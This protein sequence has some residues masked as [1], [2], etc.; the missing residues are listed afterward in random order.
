MGA[1]SWSH[2]FTSANTRLFDKQTRYWVSWEINK[3]AFLQP[4]RG[5]MPSDAATK[6]PSVWCWGMQSYVPGIPK[7]LDPLYPGHSLA[8]NAGSQFWFGG[9]SFY[10]KHCEYRDGT[11]VIKKKK[12]T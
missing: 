11:K 10:N 8:F 4:L 1:R 3:A 6:G 2:Y 7:G 9:M 12:G 5:D